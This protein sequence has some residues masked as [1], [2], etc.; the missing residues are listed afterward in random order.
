MILGDSLPFSRAHKVQMLEDSWPFLIHK[1][2]SGVFVWNRAKGGSTAV[3]V[4]K[5]LDHLFGYL[6]QEKQID[7]LV[8]QVGIVDCCPRKNS[9]FEQRVASTLC[10][11]P[12]IGY[13][14]SRLYLKC[15][16]SMSKK[17]GIDNLK[18]PLPLFKDAIRN[19]CELGSKFAKKIIFVEIIKPCNY[20]ILN[21]P[22]IFKYYSEYQELANCIIKGFSNT[23][24]IKWPDKQADF[25]LEDGHHLNLE[26]H[27][28]LA[29]QLIKE[30]KEIN[31]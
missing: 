26:G 11:I 18:V 29:A 25:V 8:I 7:L 20:L 16:S 10:K 5:E 6:G 23:K 21:E 27:S 14:F 9:E 19:I 3:D 1:Y 12:K 30:I 4:G 2:S 17:I 24:I 28:W 22:K 15:M 31:V 13:K